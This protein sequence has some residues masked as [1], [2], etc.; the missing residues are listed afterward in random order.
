M[1]RPGPPRLSA[2]RKSGGAVRLPDLDGFETSSGLRVV[3]APRGTLPLVSLH[4]VLRAGSSTDPPRK[5]GLADFTAGLLR[6]GTRRRD[7]N[8]INESVEFHG[9]SLACGA[10]EDTLSV[11]IT[12][13]SERLGIMLEIMGE[14]V[15]EPS[16][17]AHEVASAR[18]RLLAQIANDRDDPALLAE[19]AML[20]VLWGDH[21]YGHDIVGTARDVATFTRRDAMKFHRSRFGPRISLLVVVG[22]ADPLEVRRCAQ[23]AFARWREGPTEPPAISRPIG[24][25]MSGRVLV[26][27][28]P[29]QTQSQVRMG[30]MA[31]P[32]GDPDFFPATVMNTVLGGGF[33]SR[34]V[35]EI[36]VNRGLSYGAG[37]GF[38]R[39]MAGGS[40]ILSTFTQ[41]KTT[42]EIIDVALAEVRRMRRTGPSV[43]EVKAAKKYL[44][45]LF[46]MRLETNESVASA[47][48]EMRV[49][50]LGDDWVERFVPRVSTVTAPM[51]AK[52]AR[53]YLFDRPPA[54]VIVGKAAAIKKQLAGVGPLKVVQA[55]E[56]E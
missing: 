22:W 53:K 2:Q 10:E 41:N 26:V 4:L 18:N 45:G 47:I 54:M 7:A 33:T 29:D 28:K 11:R 30:A 15:R 56:I 24:I 1:R 50:D 5:Q 43:E 34:L 9:A 40:F 21:P 8:E 49:Y 3:V 16:F 14:L 46:P 12:A 27:D 13:P 55:S 39:L 23:R 38:D 48:A 25:A 6:R 51:A 36:R 17:P 37:S 44:A 19:R 52:M 35:Q 42:R 32:K 20:R 31:F